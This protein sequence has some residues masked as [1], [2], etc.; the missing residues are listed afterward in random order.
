M[1]KEIIMIDAH[2]RGKVIDT[3]EIKSLVIEGQF[4]VDGIRFCFASTVNGEDLADPALTWYL[5]FRNRNGQGEDILLVPSY[6][7]GLVRLP[8]VPGTTATQVAGKLQIQV[9]ATKVVEEETVKCWVSESATIYI[10]ENLNPDLII[11]VEPTLLDQYLTIYNAIK[12][13]AEAAAATANTHRMAA[14]SARSGAE[15]AAGSASASAASASTSATSAT[16]KASE[17]STSAEAA[18]VSAAGALESKNAAE[19][20]K[21]VAIAA[22]ATANNWMDIDGS[23]YVVSRVS[24]DGHIIKS[25]TLYEEEV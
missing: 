12:G 10:A 14:E 3:S 16:Q 15:S 22:A 13:D 18:A 17:A 21:D 1:E 11:P 24:K 2:V 9:Y 7:D 8:W 4:G 25:I 6:D 20:A 19:T 5:Q 23:P